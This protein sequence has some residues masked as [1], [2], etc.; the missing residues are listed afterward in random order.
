MGG[1]QVKA[2]STH[3]VPPL[4]PPPP[5]KSFVHINDSNDSN[6]NDEVSRVT[7]VWIEW[8]ESRVINLMTDVGIKRRVGL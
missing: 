1:Q 4:L 7:E 8:S 3:P 6:R 5:S 2:I